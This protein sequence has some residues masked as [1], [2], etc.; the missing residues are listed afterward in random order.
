MQRRA[1]YNIAKN[2]RAHNHNDRMYQHSYQKAPADLPHWKMVICAG[3][4]EAGFVQN[5][6]LWSTDLKRVKQTRRSQE[7]L[8]SPFGFIERFPKLVHVLH[9]RAQV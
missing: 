6:D 3:V 7:H 4:A 5:K 1:T 2:F 9:L 8:A